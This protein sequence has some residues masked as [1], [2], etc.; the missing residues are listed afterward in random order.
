MLSET[1]SAL[2]S[3]SPDEKQQDGSGTTSNSQGSIPLSLDQLSKATVHSNLKGELVLAGVYPR[4]YCE[5][6]SASLP[7]PS[8]PDSGSFVKACVTFLH[9]QLIERPRSEVQEG[10]GPHLMMGKTLLSSICPSSS[11]SPSTSPNS[12]SQPHSL[13]EDL[14]M[15]MNAI[16]ILVVAEPKLLNLLAAPYALFPFSAS[17]L[18]LY[19]HTLLYEAGALKESDARDQGDLARDAADRLALAGI[20]TLIL[21][22]RGSLDCLRS[23]AAAPLPSSLP[24]SP[25]SN[26]LTPPCTLVLSLF[27]F[28]YSPSSKA[29]MD[30]S[31]DLLTL[32]LGEWLEI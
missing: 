11:S 23:I 16:R 1:L 18:P 4:V 24:P 10:S 5:L 26:S 2:S 19:Y 8:L 7:P 6:A 15:V 28:S 3:L 13:I 31:L 12:P 22:G 21:I 32:L 20:Q 14:L 25:S 9:H 27:S 17:L 30:S 29:L